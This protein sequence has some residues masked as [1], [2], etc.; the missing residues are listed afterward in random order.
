MSADEQW[1]IQCSCGQ[2]FPMAHQT[3]SDADKIVLVLNHNE[4]KGHTYSVIAAVRKPVI[5][6]NGTISYERPWKY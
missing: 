2:Y 3:R 5:N 1:D 6:K 4:N